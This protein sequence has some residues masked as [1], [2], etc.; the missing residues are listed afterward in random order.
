MT[1]TVT[2]IFGGMSSDEL[3][4]QKAAQAAS[5]SAVS[6]QQSRVQADEAKAEQALDPILKARGRRGLTAFM[7]GLQDTLG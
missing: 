4:A 7:P 5:A 6:I 3:K 1:D 2:K